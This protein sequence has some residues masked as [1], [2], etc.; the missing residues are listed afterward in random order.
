MGYRST[1]SVSNRKSYS[2]DNV[3]RTYECCVH[4]Y[5]FSH[6]KHAQDISLPERYKT[7]LWFGCIMRY[8]SLNSTMHETCENEGEAIFHRKRDK[9]SIQSVA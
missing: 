9:C 6:K 2:V 5:V 8:S 3:Q 1:R 4:A 7:Q